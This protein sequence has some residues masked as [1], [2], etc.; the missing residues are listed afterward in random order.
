MATQRKLLKPDLRN[1]L[2][3]KLARQTAEIFCFDWESWARPKQLPPAGDWA[4]WLLL[5]G[6]GFGK[7]RAGAGWV[8][9]RAMEQRRRI[10]LVART[11]T[12]PRD[13]MI[14]GPGGVLN[15]APPC[16]AAAL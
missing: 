5:A 15:N 1:A 3:G 16:R 9:R 11:P 14:E 8:H 6:R 2:D 4:I 10:A 13:F 12:D 7:T